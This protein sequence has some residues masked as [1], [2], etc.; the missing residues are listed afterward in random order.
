MKLNCNF[1]RG[2]CVC[3]CDSEGVSKQKKKKKR[4]KN[5][6]E[7]GYFLKNTIMAVVNFLSPN[8]DEFSSTESYQLLSLF[9]HSVK[10]PLMFTLDII[11]ILFNICRSRKNPHPND[12]WKF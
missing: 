3:V 12:Y 11:I 10:H 5:L 8:W 9:V 6:W 7:Y 4:K 1:Q 2:V